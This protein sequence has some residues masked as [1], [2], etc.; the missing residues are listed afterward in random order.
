MARLNWIDDAAKKVGKDLGVEVRV[1]PNFGSFGKP[2]MK[3]PP[4]GIINH[5]IVGWGIETVLRGRPQDNLPPPLAHLCPRR[6]G[7]IDVIASGQANHA[8]RGGYRGLTSSTQVLG[9]ENA[10]PGDGV[11]PWPEKEMLTIVHLNAELLTRMERGPEW[12]F[13]HKEWAPG[14]KIDPRGGTKA[15]DPYGAIWQDMR[16]FRELVGHVMSKKPERRPEWRDERIFTVVVYA[17]QGTPEEY[18]GFAAIQRNASP[19]FTMNPSQAISARDRGEQV[20]CIGLN[21]GLDVFGPGKFPTNKDGYHVVAGTTN[22]SAVI[23]GVDR[24]HTA[25]MALQMADWN[26]KVGG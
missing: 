19:V 6:D 5:H 7:A 15:K 11:T 9:L 22:G 2:T 1:Q 21:A 25:L 17:R 16:S 3:D 26:W 13:A 12:T 20:I 10:H 18:A 24:G 14:R 23:F 4:L 8:G